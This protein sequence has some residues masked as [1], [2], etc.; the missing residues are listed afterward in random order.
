[1][2]DN[3]DTAPATVNESGLHVFLN[4]T[5]SSG[6]GRRGPNIDVLGS[7]FRTLMFEAHESGDLPDHGVLCLAHNINIIARG[8]ATPRLTR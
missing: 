6:M 3:P 2:T 1:M 5:V 7:V 8:R 4:A